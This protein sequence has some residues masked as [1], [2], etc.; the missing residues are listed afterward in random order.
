MERPILLSNY[1][2][3]VTPGGP[4]HATIREHVA[5]IAE[6]ER[7]VSVTDFGI[8]RD[9]ISSLASGSGNRLILL[10]AHASI[11]ETTQFFNE[12]RRAVPSFQS[13][14][15]IVFVSPF[16][17]SA[18]PALDNPDSS[19]VDTL[20]QNQFYIRMVEAY[21]WGT[22]C[23]LEC[24]GH[25]INRIDV[26]THTQF[27]GNS[28]P[29]AIP[30]MGMDHD[31]VQGWVNDL[32]R[33]WG[34][35]EMRL[36]R[37]PWAESE[38]A[39][40][41]PHFRSGV[42]TG[43]HEDN[44]LEY[45]AMVYQLGR[46]QQQAAEN[47]L[48]QASGRNSWLHKASRSEL[49]ALDERYREYS[50]ILW[51]SVKENKPKRIPQD[52]RRIRLLLNAE[53]RNNI[54]A[55][56]YI[57]DCLQDIGQSLCKGT[58]A[59]AREAHADLGRPVRILAIKDHV[60]DPVTRRQLEASFNDSFVAAFRPG[61]VVLHC[62]A[63]TTSPQGV[64][65][66]AWD[67][68]DWWTERVFSDEPL[69]VIGRIPT[70]ILNDYVAGFRLLEYDIL[71]IETEF[72][73]RFIG[74]SIIH[75]CD[76]ALDEGKHLLAGSRPRLFALSRNESAGHSYM[77]LALGAD[78]Y[79]AKSRVFSIPSLLTMANLGKWAPQGLNPKLR[80]TFFALQGLLP[81]HRS[82]LQSRRP[83][84]VVL[85]DEFDRKWI[86][87]LPKADLHYH[88]GTSISLP[89]IACLAANT[90]G[91]FLGQFGP[92]HDMTRPDDLRRELLDKTCRIAILSNLV[93]KYH[94]NAKAFEPHELIWAVARFLLHPRDDNGNIVKNIPPSF[95]PLEQVISWLNRKD[96]PS[97]EFEAC[98][99]LVL[100][101]T[102]CNRYFSTP[103]EASLLAEVDDEVAAHWSGLWAVG[104]LLGEPPIKRGLS[105][106]VVYQI[107]YLM[108]RIYGNWR[109]VLSR[110]DVASFRK[111]R[112][113][114]D[115]SILK[116][117][118]EGATNRCQHAARAV[119][120]H[121]DHLLSTPHVEW[122]NDAYRSFVDQKGEFVIGPEDLKS[123]IYVLT[124]QYSS[125]SVKEAAR[126]IIGTSPISLEHIVKLPAESSVDSRKRSLARYLVGAG[127]LGA[128]HLQYPENIVLATLDIT[129][130]NVEDNVVYSEVRCSTTGY[131]ASGMN[132]FDATDLLCLSFDISAMFF[133][134]WD[135]DKRV[136]AVQAATTSLKMA[137]GTRA[138]ALWT[139]PPRRWVRTNI[140]LGAK[141]H[142]PN[143]ARAVAELVASY[144]SRGPEKDPTYRVDFGTEDYH[145]GSWW[146][147]CAV[148]GFDLSGDESKSPLSLRDSISVVFEACVP[149]TIHAGEA[150]TAKSIW[151]AVYNLGA[152]RIGHGIRLR[153]DS[154][155]L[156]HCVSRGICM[157]LCPISNS[158]TNVFHRSPI[159]AQPA[160]A[161]RDTKRQD[162]PALD[163]LHAGLDFCIN[164]DNRSLHS[165]ETLTGDYLTLAR[166]TG[167]LSRWD[168][169]RICKAGFK[170]AFLPK[171]QIALLLRHVE[172]VVYKIASEHSG[173]NNFPPFD[174]NSKM[175]RIVR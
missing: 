166:L 14:T 34:V 28:P 77:C 154:N 140:L 137:Q 23:K 101:F 170:N 26:L 46:R 158:F 36:N 58:A 133:G 135:E 70:N 66:V 53:H 24:L 60:R 61:D 15:G 130:R 79:A 83:D 81:R 1:E 138:D 157:E 55:Q 80:P 171:D 37:G 115:G 57:L 119:V 149:T 175:K 10:D 22:F 76:R 42:F 107:A 75:W 164:T 174:M 3:V 136:N 9:T 92:G 4:N 62:L 99:L 97:R 59:W 145:P 64:S 88:I 110:D 159:L 41:S 139:Q 122:L 124:F 25:L 96:R 106:D 30:F 69:K 150:M 85:G 123:L 100:A 33:C 52:V 91:Y 128:D 120:N 162:Y 146:G 56:L 143:D 5:L 86:A 51:K 48:T 103:D 151:E 117:L 2:L 144:A 167:G 18:T 49:R 78:A 54:R 13:P 11:L 39:E 68:F 114:Y 65:N 12:L 6:S 94:K 109:D 29:E 74:P 67:T 112:R 121:I 7:A 93:A 44:L 118:A 90:S 32:R 156:S 89:T 132:V 20:R 152:Q 129:K 43:Q 134:A 82:R 104:D 72:E 47:T 131:C 45:I 168:V 108:E 148:A 98:S 95:A 125:K 142:K 102:I 147:R 161:P 63:P 141:R 165:D 35:L 17:D 111:P 173:E 155:L 16:F 50:Q 87:S 84:Q 21:G 116:S 31:A 126:D 40:G 27:L 8:S 160:E 153:E 73:T 169:L 19:L 163:F 172:Y 127:C 113:D 71:L 105:S 38:T